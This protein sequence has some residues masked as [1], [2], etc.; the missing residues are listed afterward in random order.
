M[1][2]EPTGVD[3]DSSNDVIGRLDD[4]SCKTD[5]LPIIDEETAS[6]TAVDELDNEVLEPSTVE[7]ETEVV[8]CEDGFDDTVEVE[9]DICEGVIEGVNDGASTSDDVATRDEEIA[10]STDVDEL[11]KGVLEPSTIEGDT[12]VAP[13]VDRLDGTLDG[14]VEIS[15]VAIGSVDNGVCTG[16]DVPTRDEEVA[17]GTNVDE[18]D[19][20]V[21][22]PATVDGKTEV[23]ACEDT[24]DDTVEVDVDS[25]EVGIGSVDDGACTSDD[26]A[27]SVEEVASSTDVDELDKCVLEPATVDGE[28]EVV[29]C[30]EAFRDTIGVD[31]DVSKVA[32]GGVED[33]IS[34]TE[35]VATK[36]EKLAS[37]ADVDELDTGA[38]ES[39]TVEEE[40]EVVACEDGLDATVEVDVDASEV[41]I[42]IIDDGDSTRDDVATR[43]EELAS[44]TDVDKL[45]EGV[46]KP[47]TVEGETEIVASKDGLDDTLEADVD[48]SEVAIGG[49]DDGVCTGGDVATRDKEDESG[50]NVDELDKGVLEPST[51]DGETEVGACEEALRDTIGVDV[52]VSEGAIGGV[53]DTISP[54]EDVAGN[55]DELASGTDVEELDKGVLKPSTVEGETEVVACEDG[56]D[57]TGDVDVD[58]S[59]VG[60]GSVDDGACTSDDVATNVEELASS[61]DVDEL[62]KG[63]LKPSTVE[64]ETE[65][66]ACEDGLDDT[67]D[68]DV[69]SSEVGIGSV[70]DGACTSDDVATNV[71]ELASS[72][73]V[74]ELDKGVLEP[75][76]VDGK[77]EV[78]ACEEALRD[79]IGVDLDVSEVAIGGVEDTISPTEDV[80]TGDEKLASGADVDELDT[81]ALEPS[82]VEGE[83]EVVA[84][85]DGLDVTVEVDV[86]DSEDA[87]GIDDDGDSTRDDVATR[88][89]ELAS[90][91]DVDE[92]GTGVLEPS[93]VEGETEIVACDEVLR[94]TIGVDV[95]VSEGAIGDVEDTISPAEDV[96]G[97]DDELASGTD[98]DELDKGVLKPSTVEGE[99]EVV[100]CEDGLDDT[101]DVD[102]DSSEVGI[103]SVDD[104]ACTSD[105]VAT[106]VE[107]LASSTDVDELD[108]GVLEPATVD[109]KTEVVAC[110]EALRDTIGV[111]LD[112]SEVAIGGVEDTISP[113]EDVATGDEKLASGAD[114]DELDT[115]ALEPS[116]VEGETEVVACEDGLDVTVEVDVDDS[117]DAIGIDDDGDSTRDDVATRDEELASGTDVDELGTGVLEPSIVEGETEIVACDEVLRDTIGVDVDVSEGAIGDV[118]DTISPAEDV[119]GNDDELASGTDV[120]ELDKGVLKPS[121][122][123]GETEVVACEDGL[124]ATVEVDVDGSDD[125]IGSVDDG[126]CTSDD[127]ATRDEE[128]ASGTDDDEP[129]KGVLEPSPVDGKTEVVACEEALRDTIGVDLDVS[130]VAIG[131]VEDTISPTED[132]ATGDEKLASGADVDELD[133]GALEPSTVEGETEVVACEDGLDVTVE[134]NVDDSEVAIGIDDDGDSTRDDV[135]TRDEELASGTD[136]DELG[137]GVLEPSIVEGE[138]EI[139]ACDEV[140]RDTIGVDVDVS[141]GAIGDVEDTISPAEDVAG[142]DDELA[143]GTDVDE[144]DKGVLKPSTVEGE[145][146]VVAC[147]DGLDA[148]VEVDVDGSDDAIG[149]V[150]DGSCT[151][152]DVATRDEEVASGTDDDEPDK[153]VLE[154]SPVDG[155]TEVVACEEAL[156]DTIGVDLDVSEVAIGGVEDTISPTEDVGTRDEKL[157]SGADVDEL[158]TGALEPSTVEGETEV[159][160]CK[161]GLGATVEVDV[162]ESEVAIRIVDDG[163]STRDDVAT[164]DEE[165][166]SGTDVDKLGEGVS[167]PSTVEGET[168]IVAS[169][170][171]LDDTLEA[172]VDSSEVA[173]GGVDDGVC[174]GGDVATRDTEDESGTNVDELDKGV[175]E[176]STV[177][178]D[179]EVVACEDRLDDTGEVDVDS[180][181]VTV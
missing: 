101:G 80:A 171:G 66:V 14:D 136:V 148:T 167:E 94:D 140:L 85:E 143:S 40:T 115:G 35:D 116:T 22:E 113:T 67:G 180:S 157:A 93:I 97:N 8:A 168:E 31:L 173:I 138:T 170:D 65:V 172:D 153:G 63:V 177:D 174:T 86:D 139:V 62:D 127:V 30:E 34:P 181:D 69:D 54:A 73:D 108:K 84:C 110:E 58:S 119:A 89:E 104:G 51:V 70:D 75:A 124:D 28:T 141:E 33:T 81:G 12:E 15:E 107:E 17:S 165:L 1:L 42:G 125:A 26:V 150:D 121:T 49:V 18:L 156:R 23:A 109:G 130:E 76:T 161:D 78:V 175:L 135:A 134:V 36:D 142:N 105:D 82:T 20:G 2:D 9:V 21:L 32:I 47:S 149:S 45:G 95:D 4:T 74:D 88:D 128:V 3:I 52:D 112:V 83:T 48:S 37:G 24:P 137:T 111:D 159:V 145:T 29:A 79:T 98:V 64:G 123:E 103:G 7:R 27:T 39:S 179:T 169:K 133:T 147:E 16:G 19:K 60:I 38:L 90:G 151:S 68:V 118:E 155:K 50:T 132:V 154:P 77:T 102:V 72:T 117:E 59:E 25:S 61:T 53:E 114:V 122:V 158:D 91:T 120:D 11:D 100:A 131:G 57:D 163:D 178:G 129:D 5:E 164:R 176:P 92:L 87:I 71:E 10:S 144:L 44:G 162:D 152:D 99:T 106:N 160:A 126:S 55:D 96:A 13:C 56:L 6:S 146:E 41:A 43:D 46:R 166:A